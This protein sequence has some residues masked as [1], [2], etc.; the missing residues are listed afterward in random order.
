[1]QAEMLPRYAFSID[2][3]NASKISMIMNINK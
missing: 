1:M 2:Y 3:H